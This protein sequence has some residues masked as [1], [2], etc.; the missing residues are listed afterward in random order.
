VAVRDGD[1]VV[2]RVDD[3][4]RRDEV[5]DRLRHGEARIHDPQPPHVRRGEHVRWHVGRRERD[6]GQRAGNEVVAQVPHDRRPL[7]R[8]EGQRVGGGVELDQQL[9]GHEGDAVEGGICLGFARRARPAIAGGDRDRETTQ[10]CD[11]ERQCRSRHLSP[12]RVR[13]EWMELRGSTR[14]MSRS[15]LQFKAELLADAV[16]CDEALARF[17]DGMRR[18]VAMLG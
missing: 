11:P 3:V 10:C 4:S 15:V 13:C 17:E 14:A 7:R 16:Y 18:C 12:P 2:V 1:G 9:A 8:D 5:R 6:V